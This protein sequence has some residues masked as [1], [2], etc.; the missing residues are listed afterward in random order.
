LKSVLVPVNP[1]EKKPWQYVVCAVVK[2]IK[3]SDDKI[4]EVIRVQEKLHQTYLR[5]RRKGGIGIYPMEKIK[6]PI[7]FIAVDKDKIKFRP[8][9]YPK[10]ITGAQILSK[11]PT[12]RDYGYLLEGNKKYPVF[13]D[14]NGTVMS[15][16]PIIN[17][18]DV[19]KVYDSTKDIFIECTGVE[20]ESLMVTL[21]ILTTMFADMG[22]K[23][24][25]FDVNYSGKK[26]RT[27]DFSTRKKVVT[28]GEVEKLLGIKLTV[29]EIKKLLERM[30]FSAT[31][32][33]SKVEV[34]V[35]SFRTDIWHNVDVIDDVG[36]AYGYNKMVPRFPSVGT[37]GDEFAKTKVKDVIAGLLA[38]LGLVEVFTE[39]LTNEDDQYDKMNVKRGSCIKIPHAV[40]QSL[41]MVRTWLT[42][43]L[44]RSLNYNR[45]NRYPQAIYEISDIVVSDKKADVRARNVTKLG[46]LLADL[47]SSFTDA[48]Q[49]L[50]TLAEVMEWDL[51][52]KAK[53]YDPFIAGRSGAVMINGKEVGYIGEFHPAV[54]NNW[55]LTVPVAGFE[56]D[57]SF[58]E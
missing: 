10:E 44:F 42:P 22:G 17:S 34:E 57:L 1:D 43:C 35:P 30:M 53:D 11:H 12:G 27:P 28:P 56:I 18:H 6:L 50:Q 37:V 55:G 16:P 54:I 29:K 51:K 15:M 39:A 52:V 23:I 41:N 47:G 8:L 46:V 49:V 7:K 31:V 13:M 45:S 4:K 40:E 26:V 32:K 5:N 2:G 24:Y 19:G 21:N 20:L 25:A 33:G 3:F 58:L 36:R 14:A 9:E 38:D 48:K